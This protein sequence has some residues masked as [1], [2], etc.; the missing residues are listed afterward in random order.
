MQN[1]IEIKNLNKIFGNLY[2]LKNIN[3][4]IKE[5]EFVA[6]I[7]PSGSGKTTLL[8]ILSLLD[9]ASSGE[10]LLLEEDT[11]CLDPVQKSKLRRDE[12]GLIFQ[13]FHLIP[14][15]NVLENIMLAQYYH[16]SCDKED[17]VEL[18]KQ[19]GLEDRLTHLPSMLSGGE[20]QRVC[21]ARALIN[22][23]HILLADEPTGNLDEVNEKKILELF[24]G[25]KKTGKSIVLITHNL[26]LTKF[27]DRTIVLSHGEI[28]ANESA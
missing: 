13:Q 25:L 17:A 2:A 15:L 9:E 8:N 14:Y 23:P 20:Q 18:A 1:I 6:I 28:K 5:G 19:V 22:N 26:E 12:I 3:L 21:I 11:S 4:E 16:S 27:V 10:Y 24:M 7:G